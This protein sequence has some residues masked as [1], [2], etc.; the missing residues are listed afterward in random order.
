M[1]KRGRV[2]RCGERGVDAEMVVKGE[3][4]LGCL[5]AFACMECGLI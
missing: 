4:S 2:Y 1:G 5:A 3:G